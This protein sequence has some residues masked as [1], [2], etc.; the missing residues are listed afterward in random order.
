MG[1]TRRDYYKSHAKR[2]FYGL[3]W[4]PGCQSSK[5]QQL[6]AALGAQ[7][8]SLFEKMLT[9]VKYFVFLCNLVNILRAG[10]CLDLLQQQKSRFKSGVSSKCEKPQH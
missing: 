10:R 3:R 6:E 9:N 2:Y 1:F 8:E 5:Y 4:C 7:F